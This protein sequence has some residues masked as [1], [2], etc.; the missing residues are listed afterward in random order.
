MK[1]HVNHGIDIVKRSDW[2]KDAHDVVGYHHDRID[3]KGYPYGFNGETIFINARIFTIADVFDALTSMRPYQSPMPFD[4][5]MGIIE[6]GRGSLFD[7]VPLDTFTTISKSL[8]DRYSNCP[9]QTLREK[10]ESITKQNF[11]Y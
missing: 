10:L 4:Q 6:Q 5:A 1:G 7:P 8:Y 2:L 9:E 11:S 3:G